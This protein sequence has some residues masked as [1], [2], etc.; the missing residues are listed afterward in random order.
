MH[1]VFTVQVKVKILLWLVLIFF[2]F[3]FESFIGDILATYPSTVEVL[4]K[5]EL[6]N[7]YTKHKQVDKFL[8]LFLVLYFR[9]YKIKIALNK[10]I[11][12]FLRKTAQN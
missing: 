4:S 6:L 2:F 10:E 1:L 9:K 7:N 3:G 12:N 5:N 8:E 11:W